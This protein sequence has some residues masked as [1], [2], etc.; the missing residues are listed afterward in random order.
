MAVIA[1]E[2]G[3]TRTMLYRHFATR[4]ELFEALLERTTLRQTSKIVELQNQSASLATLVVE[5]FVVVATELAQD[6]LYAIFAEETEAGNVAH[7]LM[8]A[9]LFMDFVESLIK[10]MVEAEGGFLREGV[11]IIDAAKFLVASALGML[12]GIVPG[13]EDPDQVR[14]YVTVFILPAI[15]ASPPPPHGVFEPL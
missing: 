1:R 8:N 12:L 3:Y 6:P 14:R 13:S 10:Q 15:M 4:N 11:R 2:A 5:G 7:L 9:P